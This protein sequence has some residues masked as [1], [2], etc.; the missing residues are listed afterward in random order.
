MPETWALVVFKDSMA[1]HL[2]EGQLHWLITYC[3]LT[4]WRWRKAGVFSVFRIWRYGRDTQKKE[5]WLISTLRRHGYY[6]HANKTWWNEVN[7]K[8]VS[9]DEC[10]FM[11]LQLSPKQQLRSSSPHRAAGFSLASGRMQTLNS[12]WWFYCCRLTNYVPAESLDVL[13]AAKG[14]CTVMLRQIST[15]NE[16]IW[17]ALS[18]SSIT[19]CNY[20]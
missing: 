11:Q 12:F 7:R 16:M 20:R 9:R 14:G 15:V 3:C 10:L 4:L 5:T 18:S 13:W 2:S 19:L 8:R 6:F 17:T 1:L